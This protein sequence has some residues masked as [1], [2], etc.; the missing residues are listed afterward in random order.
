VNEA[1]ARLWWPGESAVGK[2]IKMGASSM[3]CA[4]VVGVVENAKRFGFVEDDA[5]QFYAPLT[6]LTSEG[7][8]N[9]LYV[10]PVRNTSAFQAQLQRRMQG[11]APALPYV[12]VEL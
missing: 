1:A 7:V 12:A 2:C 6:Q 3:P 8:A 5:V 9:V 11:A 10:R 4:Q